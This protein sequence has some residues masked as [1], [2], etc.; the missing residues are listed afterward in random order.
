[1]SNNYVK[2]DI[3]PFDQVFNPERMQ[4]HTVRDAI[5]DP[6]L[7]IDKFP[8]P[9]YRDP[10]YH[11]LNKRSTIAHDTTSKEIKDYANKKIIKLDYNHGLRNGS[12]IM[13]STFGRNNL[14]IATSNE[15]TFPSQGKRFI[16][17]NDVPQS[18]TERSG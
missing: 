14:N 6:N 5:V 12:L 4:A 3:T 15:K 13:Q 8:D 1:M 18:P 17:F 16:S 2:F 11:E 10:G 9:L 7:T